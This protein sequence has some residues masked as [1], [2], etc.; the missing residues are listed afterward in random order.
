ML[1]SFLFSQLDNICNNLK[2][3]MYDKFHADLVS[4]EV[5]GWDFLL[6]CQTAKLISSQ[7]LKPWTGN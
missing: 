5:M 7:Y 6:K 1:Q 4:V 2:F 3:E